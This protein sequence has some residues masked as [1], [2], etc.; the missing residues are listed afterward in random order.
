MPRLIASSPRI[1]R[2]AIRRESGT[3][4]AA[5][6]SPWNSVTMFDLA[7]AAF[8]RCDASANQADGFN[9]H[10]GA[11]TQAFVFTQDCTSINNAPG[12]DELQL[13]DD[14]RRLRVD[15]P[16]RGGR[17]QRRRPDRDRQRRHDDVVHRQLLVRQLRRH[18]PPRSGSAERLPCR[19]LRRRRSGAAVPQKSRG[20]RIALR[21]ERALQHDPYARRRAGRSARFTG[22]VSPIG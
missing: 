3:V 13:Q 11:Q 18:D 4:T 22:T 21:A 7:G 15:R 8:I 1:A 17:A 5:A 12:R 14:A 9:G 19:H 2:P 16:A 10:R 6:P 20:G